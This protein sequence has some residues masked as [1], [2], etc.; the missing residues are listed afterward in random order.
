M[1]SGLRFRLGIKVC[2]SCLIFKFEICFGGSY[3]GLGF[4]ILV[5]NQVVDAVLGFRFGGQVL[6][7][8]F[9]FRFGIQIIF[10]FGI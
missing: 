6:D 1:G 10:R 5:W 4:A 9:R 7:S 2:D 3:S 8:G